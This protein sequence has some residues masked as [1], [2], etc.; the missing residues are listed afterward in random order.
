M[1]FG[2][3]HDTAEPGGSLESLVKPRCI[4]SMS[5]A[6]EVE[7]VHKQVLISA[8]GED[9]RLKVWL[10]IENTNSM[11]TAKCDDVEMT[12]RVCPGS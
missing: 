9:E 11:P 7:T 3:Q 10:A 2:G 8:R 5:L 4:G 12:E 6:A 1:A